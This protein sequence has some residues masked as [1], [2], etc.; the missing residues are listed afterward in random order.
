MALTLRGIKG[1]PLTYAEADA[2]FSGLADGSLLTAGSSSIGFLQSGTGAVSRT[3]QD[4]LRE[5]VSVKDFGAVGDGVTDDTVAIQAAI[6]S[7]G[8]TA[9]QQRC[10]RLFIPCGCA[11]SST[12]V[13]QNKSLIIEGNGWGNTQDTGGH[14]SYLKWIGAAG[15]PM[16]KIINAQGFGIRDIRFVGKSSAKPSAAINFNQQAGFASESN[17]LHNVHIGT[18]DGDT[19]DDA[20]QFTNGILLDGLASNNSEFLFS[21]IDIHKCVDGIHVGYTQMI[22]HVINQ[23]SIDSCTNGI[24]MCGNAVGSGWKFYNNAV[25]INQPRLDDAGA[26]CASYVSIN[27]YHSES[28]GRLAVLKGG[29]LTI[30]SG[31]FQITPNANADG[32]II[33]ASGGGSVCVA[34]LVLKDF[35]WSRSSAP[36]TPPFMDFSGTG[37][38]TGGKSIVLDGV[39]NQVAFLTGG[40]NGL[41]VL[42]GDAT[43]VRFVYYRQ[44][45]NSTGG[46]VPAIALNVIGGVGANKEW[47]IT[48]YNV[49]PY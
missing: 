30:Q 38:T 13:A 2:N 22:D 45:V 36:A 15:T 9:V 46:V 31:A 35:L 7:F 24:Y 17:F 32:K 11:I 29:D 23:I 5:V 21:N 6:D 3:A 1:S 39:Q 10:G 33:D 19:S 16:L 27:G 43:D 20:V 44:R 47:D 49:T 40:T 8:S 34:N 28:A 26:N 18:M 37:G 12:L 14:A 4:K 25:D 41:K 48:R 42:T